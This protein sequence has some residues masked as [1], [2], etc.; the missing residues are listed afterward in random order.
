MSLPP[1]PAKKRRIL[2]RLLTAFSRTPGPSAGGGT[3]HSPIRRDSR[4]RE[5]EQLTGRVPSEGPRSLRK[6][7]LTDEDFEWIAL[8]SDMGAGQVR[9]YKQDPWRGGFRIT[10]PDA[11]LAAQAEALL[12]AWDVQERLSRA[13]VYA[14]VYGVGLLYIPLPGDPQEIVKPNSLKALR[15]RK[16]GDVWVAPE[17]LTH[18]TAISKRQIQGYDT[19]ED[20]SIEFWRITSGSQL[21]TVHS[22]RVIHVQNW[23][24]SD[25][26]MGTS[27]FHSQYDTITDFENCNVAATEALIKSAVGLAHL[28]LPE[29][30]TDEDWEWAD[31]N[32]KNIDFLTEF[33]TE[34]G[35]E[36]DVVSMDKGVNPTPYLDHQFHRLSLVSRVPKTIL[37]GTEAGKV[38]GSEWNIKE[39]HALI[40]DMRRELERYIQ[41]LLRK[42]QLWGILP[43]GRLEV[44]WGALDEPTEG[45]RA[46]IRMRLTRSFLD[47]STAITNMVNLGWRELYHDGRLYLV[48]Q[49][50]GGALVGV[51]VPVVEAVELP[52]EAAQNIAE[53]PIPPG[54]EEAKDK[55][56]IPPE[57]L[58]VLREKWKLPYDRVEP[59]AESQLR[60]AVDWAVIRW[61]AQFETV[62]RAAGMQ[63]DALSEEGDAQPTYNVAE[64][65][66][67]ALKI[68][69]PDKKIRQAY[70]DMIEESLRVGYDTTQELL[71]LP[72]EFDIGMPWAEEYLAAH[73]D[74]LT[75]QTGQDISSK[76]IEAMREGLLKG[77]GY[78]D[79]TARIKKGAKMW[80]DETY[81][82]VHKVC[83]SALN[84][85]RVEAGREVAR[86]RWVYIT[87]GDERVRPEHRAQEGNVYPGDMIKELLSDWNCRC[88]CVPELAV[89]REMGRTLEPEEVGAPPLA[90]G[91]EK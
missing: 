4:V 88:T 22:S 28:K 42:A 89:E 83:H 36:V 9:I 11:E 78:P 59:D 52:E 15:P 84:A 45:E 35:W 68:K 51:E 27:H 26:P 80:K 39:Y 75:A 32:F 91:G 41:E 34:Q 61:L 56:K 50:P 71:G 38:T 20:G 3:H 63:V 86:D 54:A 47:L 72:G 66:K 58:A 57:V 18:L 17:G 7:R 16:S 19:G 67:G 85:A 76:M 43:P 24:L 33:V 53:P 64:V 69:F 10:S 30:A 82:I 77:E 29:G 31:Q 5:L 73:V 14:K 12:D 13:Y 55:L 21:F 90:W 62:A 40:S 87:M 48:K 2:D 25:D 8:R 46:Q 81:K 6:A 65:V 23:W 74:T 70:Q 1:P 49:M 79:I 44:E 37:M 60:E